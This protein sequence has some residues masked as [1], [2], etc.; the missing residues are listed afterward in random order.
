MSQHVLI[1]AIIRCDRLPQIENTL[2]EIGVKGMTLSKVEGYGEYADTF[3]PDWMV[4]HSKI[5][6]FLKQTRQRLFRM[7]LLLQATPGL[8]GMA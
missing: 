8:K 7:P 3:S 4:C 1:I 6:I 2:K 5:E